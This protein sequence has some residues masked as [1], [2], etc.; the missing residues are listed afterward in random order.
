M[1]QFFLLRFYYYITLSRGS[2][3]V[4][5]PRH[6]FSPAIQYF[7]QSRGPPP[8]TVRFDEESNNVAGRLVDHG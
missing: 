2:R 8:V 5:P 6:L 1:P 7:L 3:S 4:E